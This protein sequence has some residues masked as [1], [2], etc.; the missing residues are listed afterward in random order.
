MLFEEFLD[1]ISALRTAKKLADSR[2]KN[3]DRRS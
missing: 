2:G 1:K 3:E